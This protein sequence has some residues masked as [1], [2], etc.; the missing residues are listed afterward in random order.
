MKPGD[1]GLQIENSQIS[2]NE[3]SECESYQSHKTLTIMVKKVR[4]TWIGKPSKIMNSNTVTI[5]PSQK[6]G[7]FQYASGN[8][9]KN[10]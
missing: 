10:S 9:K 7:S 1:P 3:Y 2:Q 6:K 5:S 4:E 8:S